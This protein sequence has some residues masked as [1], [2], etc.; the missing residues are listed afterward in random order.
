MQAASRSIYR[1]V[2]YIPT[3]QC[4]R[5]GLCCGGVINSSHYVGHYSFGNIATVIVRI[6]ASES[7]N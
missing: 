4:K 2:L 7:R 6:D 5:S 3:K 1:C